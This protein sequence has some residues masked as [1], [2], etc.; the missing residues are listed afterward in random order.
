MPQSIAKVAVHIVYSTKFRQRWLQPPE[1]RDELYAYMATILRNKVDSPAIVINGAEDHVHILCLLSRK[2]AIMKIIEES[3]TETSKWLKQQSHATCDFS[4]QSGYGIFSVSESN[5]PE[6]KKYI[7]NQ[8][9]H[10]RTM[11]FQDEFRILCQ[12]HG[13]ELNERYAWD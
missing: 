6:V 2:F 12:R 7:L 4:W 8:E 1:L 3:K 11:T 9:E 5:I 13:I 10:H